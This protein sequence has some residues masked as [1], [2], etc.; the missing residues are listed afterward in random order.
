MA[1][2]NSKKGQAF[3]KSSY[4]ELL[5]LKNLPSWLALACLAVFAY[6]P[7]RLRDIFAIVC[8]YLVFL[9]PSKPRRVAY[10]NLRTA[11]PDLSAKECRAISRRSIAVGFCVTLAY[12]EPTF[13]PSFMLKRRWIVH[14]LEHL[15]KAREEGGP[16]IFL[17][18]HTYAIDRCGLYLSYVGL[19]MCTMVRSQKNKVFDWFLNQQRL[20]FGGSVYE[21]DAGLRTLIREL[22]SNHSCFFLPDEDLGDKSARFIDFMGVPKATVSTL[23]KLAKVGNA[24]VMQLFST[25]NIKKAAFEIFLS[26]VFENYPGSDL[27]Q[28]LR[29]MNECIEHEL[30]RHKEQYMWI[31]RIFKTLPDPSYPDIYANT[32]TSLY[33]SGKSIDVAGRRRPYRPYDEQG[34][35]N[36]D[37]L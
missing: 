4:K 16:I 23:P 25:Y 21:R 20:R 34:Q 11:F 5:T 27:D 12:G 18:P 10:A 17:A 24:Q 15:Q 32:Y 9:I 3:D 7:N 30:V 19:E 29:R 36:N 35:E 14:G 28:D 26:P 6:I 8:A 37:S 13:L 31:L 33:K 22:K 1:L 2:T